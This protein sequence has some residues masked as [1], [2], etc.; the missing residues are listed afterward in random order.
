MHEKKISCHTRKMLTG[1]H[2]CVTFYAQDDTKNFDDVLAKILND[3]KKQVNSLIRKELRKRRLSFTNIQ[4][5]EYPLRI[6]RDA[7]VRV[8]LVEYRVLVLVVKGATKG[9]Y[10]LAPNS[11]QIG[12]VPHYVELT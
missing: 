7:I 2:S 5:Y 12:S 3:S 6:Q 10:V 4:V 1:I 9:D 11:D 8:H